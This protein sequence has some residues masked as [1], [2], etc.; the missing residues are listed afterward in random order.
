MGPD[1]VP[2]VALVMTVFPVAKKPRPCAQPVPLSHIKSFRAVQLKGKEENGKIV[3]EP[4]S[5]SW[6]FSSSHVLAILDIDASLSDVAS[7]RLT[8]TPES[9]D[10][11]A[12][13]Q[14]ENKPEVEPSSPKRRRKTS[15]KINFSKVF[16][17][18]HR[19]AKTL[20]KKAEKE[21]SAQPES[22]KPQDIRRSE[23]GRK[24]IKSILVKMASLD[25]LHFANPAFD[26][27]TQMCKIKTISEQYSFADFVNQAPAY[28]Q[29]KFFDKRK[30]DSYGA[31]V[32][33][34]LG[35]ALDEMR[36][37]KPSRTKWLALISDVRS[38]K[39]DNEIAM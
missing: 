26:A 6:I 33:A 23:A 38:A 8:L 10:V 9:L 11:F 16:K 29:F 37:E 24:K 17:G 31:A 21:S 30:G 35:S 12:E 7:G 15:S 39:I 13:V 28:Y 18:F 36:N 32:C 20:M 34:E 27:K 4:T 2:T 25:Q 3:F 19:A 1:Q 22:I 14:S 5:N